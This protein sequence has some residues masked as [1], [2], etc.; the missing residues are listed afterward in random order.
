MPTTFR[1]FLRTS[2]IK[3]LYVVFLNKEGRYFLIPFKNTGVIVFEEHNIEHK[4]IP[5]IFYRQLIVKLLIIMA[6]ENT[7]WAH[8]NLFL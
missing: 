5:M 1:I 7:I 6:F 3:I 4:P 2:S 8:S